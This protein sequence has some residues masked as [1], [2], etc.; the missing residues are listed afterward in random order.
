MTP[1]EELTELIAQL[2]TV[3]ANWVTVTLPA[4]PRICIQFFSTRQSR[5]ED[6]INAETVAVLDLPCSALSDDEAERAR[7][8]FKSQ[9]MLCPRELK[10]VD[11]DNRP[12]MTV[13]WE[14][15]VGKTPAVAARRGLAC[16]ETVYAI[17]G[18]YAIESKVGN[19]S[20]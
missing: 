8:W 16:M 1:D 9:N 12:F 18:P 3:P 15:V 14:L 19:F 20:E 10:S 13:S 7:E 5:T 2:L 6:F 17:T 11:Q 4:D